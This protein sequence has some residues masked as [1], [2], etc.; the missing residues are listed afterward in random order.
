MWNT[1]AAVSGGAAG[2]LTGLIFIV[3]AFRYDTIAVSEE[4][5]SR[6]AQ[7]L[8]LFLTVTVFA[9]LLT[10][11]Q[12]EQALG[13][14]FVLIAVLAGALLRGLDKT[15]RKGQ[16][17]RPSAALAV[18]LVAFTVCLGGSGLVV[19]FGQEWGRYLLVAAAVDGLVCGAYGAWT[20]LTRAGNSTT[21]SA[22]VS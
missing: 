7:A 14:E 5:R 1:F 3:V 22:S 10:V 11:P 19:A 15:A 12:Y 18:A 4:Y 9:V 13:A 16:V 2:G 6:A 20:F 8:S 21:E 17:T